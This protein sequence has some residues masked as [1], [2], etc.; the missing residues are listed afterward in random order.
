MRRQVR[1][2]VGV[3]LAGL[4]AGC[5]SSGDAPSGGQSAAGTKT[6]D[7]HRDPGASAPMGVQRI[8][9][10]DHV[11][12]VRVPADGCVVGQPCA[13]SVEAI[14]LGD[15]KINS[16]YPHRFVVGA[17]A[18]AA[19][20]AGAFTSAE[21]NV[22]SVPLT[23]IAAATGPATVSG[24]LKLGVCNADRCEIYETQVAVTVAAR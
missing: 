10:K 22:A 18:G 8:A 13:V 17:P 6:S 14:A 9:G 21:V 5:D 3:G 2:V 23:V 24:E 15:F 19:V 1:V 11:V 12:D 16:E 20:T 7:P 4:L